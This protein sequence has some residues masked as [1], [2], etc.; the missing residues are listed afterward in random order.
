M[1][2]WQLPVTSLVRLPLGE[3]LGLPGHDEVISNI[4]FVTGCFWNPFYLAYLINFF[5]VFGQ[6]PLTI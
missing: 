6:L 5:M 4:S 2:S 1:L 3:N